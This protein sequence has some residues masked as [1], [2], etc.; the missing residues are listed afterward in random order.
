MTQNPTP[1]PPEKP[2]AAQ[3]IQQV[4]AELPVGRELSLSG[5]DPVAALDALAALVDQ[6]EAA[7]AEADRA[8]I[9]VELMFGIAHA[10]SYVKDSCQAA[11]AR[12]AER[13]AKERI[14]NV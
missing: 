3:L 11:I 4:R 7:L 13:R 10:P 9:Q 14:G 1:N 5:G 8:L 12:E 6:Q 2:T